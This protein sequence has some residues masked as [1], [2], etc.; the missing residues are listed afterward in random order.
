M[1]P[2]LDGRRFED[3]Y[4]FDVVFMKNLDDYLSNA[5]SIS[6]KLYDYH[7]INLGF[8]KISPDN[9]FRPN[10]DTIFAVDGLK[11]DDIRNSFYEEK[12]S[13]IFCNMKI[14]PVRRI[15]FMLSSSGKRLMASIELGELS[16]FPPLS[17]DRTWNHAI[18]TEKGDDIWTVLS[19]PSEDKIPYAKIFSMKN[20][21][22]E[23]RL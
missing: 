20:N 19:T 16:D 6:E 8:A 12:Y 22:L 1:K 5:V 3:L 17:P 14:E 13:D 11:V 2:H 4:L 15:D 10:R 9:L 23:N 21:S 7:K 18:Y